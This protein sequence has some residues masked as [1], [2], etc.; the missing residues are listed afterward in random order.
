[1]YD[2]RCRVCPFCFWLFLGGLW[3]VKVAADHKTGLP[4]MDGTEDQM[5]NSAK[6]SYFHRGTREEY[7]VQRKLECI[8]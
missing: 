7:G 4:G 1:M 3:C 8:P 2:N 6:S 5:T